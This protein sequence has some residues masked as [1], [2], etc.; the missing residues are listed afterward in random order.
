MIQRFIF[1]S[2]WDALGGLKGPILGVLGG[3]WEVLGF[4]R[5]SEVKFFFDFHEGA[6]A[7]SSKPKTVVADFSNVHD[8]D[9]IQNTNRPNL[10]CFFSEAP[11]G[12]DPMVAGKKI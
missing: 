4:Y 6:W 9:G 10:V 7:A 11:R 12:T 1:F 8:G 2:L 5:A 3:H